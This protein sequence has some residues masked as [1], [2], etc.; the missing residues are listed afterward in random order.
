ML[1]FKLRTANTDE[2]QPLPD[3]VRGLFAKIFGHRGYIFHKGFEHLFENGLQLVTPRK[4]MNNRQL[5][6]M[7]K[8]L[9]QKRS[10]IE[11]INYQ[12]ENIATIE[13]SRQQAYVQ[14]LVAGLIAYTYREKKPSLNLCTPTL[15]GF[16]ALVF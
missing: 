8:I 11:T 14:H 4:N 12:L 6:L 1:S 2:S 3:L 5:P 10:L 16:P 9:L 7:G 13:H 15:D